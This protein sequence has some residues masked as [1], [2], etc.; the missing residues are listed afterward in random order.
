M[1]AN[2]QTHCP[3]KVSTVPFGEENL[4]KMGFYRSYSGVRLY[5]INKTVYYRDQHGQS[6]SL[7]T[8]WINSDSNE[9]PN[10]DVE[11]L[12]EETTRR[13]L[14]FGVTDVKSKAVVDLADLKK[15]GFTFFLAPTDD[16]G[17][18]LAR[19]W[20]GDKYIDGKGVMASVQADGRI[21]L[22]TSDLFWPYYR[23]VHGLSQTTP[24]NDPII[25]KTYCNWIFASGLG[26]L[27]DQYYSDLVPKKGEVQDPD[28]NA[29]C[30]Q[31][32]IIASAMVVSQPDTPLRYPFED[33]PLHGGG[34]V[35]DGL[36]QV[37][38][39]VI[40]TKAFLP[41]LAPLDKAETECYFELRMYKDEMLMSC[42]DRFVMSFATMPP[43]FYLEWNVP[44]T[45]LGFGLYNLRNLTL[46]WNDKLNLSDGGIYDLRAP[47]AMAAIYSIRCE[48]NAIYNQLLSGEVTELGDLSDTVGRV[49]KYCEHLKQVPIAPREN[50]D[51]V[52]EDSFTETEEEI[53][54][55]SN[56]G[57]EWR[58]IPLLWDAIDWEVVAR[59]DG[60]TLHDEWDRCRNTAVGFAR[61][62]PYVERAASFAS[63]AY[64][65]LLE[66]TMPE[67]L[68]SGRVILGDTT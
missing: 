57:G 42:C 37:G 8:D 66:V 48:L 21:D 4:T 36:V 16:R 1:P 51:W 34:T 24:I 62:I 68:G 9:L 15:E 54:G 33:V 25:E 64:T 38:N 2:V 7:I 12:T 35:S 52:A 63:T 39:R 67:E 6:R 41:F 29:Y 27:D 28:G 58:E 17:V 10:T 45:A 23:D 11:R 50:S 20:A 13:Y 32:M 53:Y 3:Y 40:T 65:Q 46:A 30:T 44:I 61:T 14:E 49:I 59:F 26:M 60:G 47:D 56:I 22:V 55:D 31:Y 19:K 43:S 5:D 18:T